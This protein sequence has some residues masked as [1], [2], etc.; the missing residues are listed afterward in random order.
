[1]EDT[2]KAMAQ[3]YGYCEHCA[4]DAILFV[5]RERYAG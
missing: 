1:V 2:L 5:M 4:K 3:R